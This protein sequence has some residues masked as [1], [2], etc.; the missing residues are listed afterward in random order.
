MFVQPEPIH[1]EVNPNY[2]NNTKHTSAHLAYNTL[3]KNRTTPPDLS[4]INRRIS[5]LML[6]KGRQDRAMLNA[7]VAITI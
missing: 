6:P 3:Q 5:G 2:I 4:E 1:L 7:N